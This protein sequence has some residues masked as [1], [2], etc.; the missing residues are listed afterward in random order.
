MVLGRFTAPQHAFAA[1]RATMVAEGKDA[2]F[3]PTM[4]QICRGGLRLDRKLRYEAD[5][6]GKVVPD[7]VPFM[8]MTPFMSKTWTYG[9]AE[10]RVSS[11]ASVGSRLVRIE[12]VE[13]LGL[14]GREILARTSE[15]SRAVPDLEWAYDER[16]EIEGRSRSAA[17]RSLTRA[18]MFGDVGLAV[19]GAV[20][21]TVR[22]G[23]D[24][25]W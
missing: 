12:Q 11:M 19:S 23:A 24:L 15:F 2:S 1:V 14:R 5:R 9:V 20:R 8:S 18:A 4:A 3:L 22:A 17:W 16:A 6:L 25:V 7:G 13:R 21:T 10:G